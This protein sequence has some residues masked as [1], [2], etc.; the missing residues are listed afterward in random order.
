VANS[1]ERQVFLELFRRADG[2][3]GRM[4]GALLG[5]ERK[6]RAVRLR[7]N[8]LGLKVRELAKR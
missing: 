1:V 6:G 3:F 8:Q 4:A 2:D 7:F 5:D